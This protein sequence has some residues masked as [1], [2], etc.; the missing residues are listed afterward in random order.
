MTA[1][2]DLIDLCPVFQIDLGVLRPS[3]FTIART[4]N[5]SHI[6]CTRLGVGGSIIDWCIDV[7]LSVKRSVGIVISAIYVLSDYSV[8]AVVVHMRLID[9]TG[10]ERV[11]A[12]STTKE[13]LDL[14]GGGAWYINNST[15]CETLII[16]ATINILNVTSEKVND[17]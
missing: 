5:R 6:P 14:N 2:I 3:I 11:T 4:E 16:T 17:C 12:I 9:I 1:A 10:I 15:P 8:C 13:I 7:D